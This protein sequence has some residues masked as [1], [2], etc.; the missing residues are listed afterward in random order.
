M[1]GQIPD[2]LSE[3]QC[4]IPEAQTETNSVSKSENGEGNWRRREGTGRV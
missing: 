3:C 4:H 2:E 1:P